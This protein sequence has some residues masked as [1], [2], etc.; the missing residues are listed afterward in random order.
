L[1]SSSFDILLG[2]TLGIL[3]ILDGKEP[4]EN[5]DCSLLGFTQLNIIKMA[6]IMSICNKYGIFKEFLQ[7]ILKLIQPCLIKND[8]LLE[9]FLNGETIN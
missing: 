7:A 1:S 6:F 2:D 4:V 3:I 8:F 5:P 9:N